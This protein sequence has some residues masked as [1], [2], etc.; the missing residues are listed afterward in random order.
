MPPARS[1]LPFLALVI[2][3]GAAR[4]EVG[5]TTYAYKRVG[6]LEIRADVRR[7]AA[8]QGQGRRPVLM[9]IHG[10]ALIFGGRASLPPIA[11]ALLAANY[12]VVSI[13]YR[14]A[15][16]TRLPAIVG[17]VED[18]YRW[19]RERGPGLFGADPDRIA[20]AGGS[21]GGYLALTLG[22]RAHP[23]PVALVSFWGY[24]DLVGPWYSEPSTNPRHRRIVTTRENAFAQVSGPPIANEADRPGSGAMF[25]QY[26]RQ[27]GLWPEAVTGW[28]PHR[29]PGRF[30]PYMPLRNV[31]PGY[32]PTLLVHGER[33]TD[34]PHAQSE[35]MAAELGRNGVEHELVSVPRG[36]HGLEGADPRAVEAAYRRAFGFLRDHLEKR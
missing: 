23:G 33:D 2:G 29:E 17:D 18:A 10:G 13:D 36:E 4:S 30:Y 25:Y 21:A 6:E 35:A 32:P 28:N 26:C 20:V 14:L 15:P 11:E 24:G 12:A 5:T 31:T 16:E 7:D 9:W 34:V 22:F 19:I 1:L 27:Q 3:A 8:A